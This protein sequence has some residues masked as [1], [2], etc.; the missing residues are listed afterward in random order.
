MA[1]TAEVLCGEEVPV[2]EIDEAKAGEYQ[3]D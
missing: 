3:G 1:M 2:R